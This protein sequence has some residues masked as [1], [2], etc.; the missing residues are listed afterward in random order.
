MASRH[1][2]RTIR[3]DGTAE[4][5]LI[6]V[7]DGCFILNP[8]AAE[9]TELPPGSAA[10]F[11][12]HLRQDY[13]LAEPYPH[14][15]FFWAHFFP[16]GAMTELLAWPSTPTGQGVLH[17]NPGNTLHRRILEACTRCDHYYH[18]DFVRRRSLALLALEEILRLIQQIN[19]QRTVDTLDDRVAL[20][21]AYI[22]RNIRQPL[23]LVAIAAK[24]GL[25]ASRFAHLFSRNMSCGPMEYVEKLRIKLAAGMLTG[26]S[27]PIAKIAEEAGFGSSYYFSKRF[28]KIKGISPSEWRKLGKE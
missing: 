15:R 12:P 26:T 10:L 21:L 6:I 17:W 24:V 14:G 11:P 4:W 3:P 16:E 18:S 8:E 19:P 28:H 2:R 9:P 25:S 23:S 13:M 20:A 7:F 22:S 5:G 27:L 1:R